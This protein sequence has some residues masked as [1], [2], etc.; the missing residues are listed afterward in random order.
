MK[1]F[2]MM[3]TVCVALL[4]TQVV[5]AERVETVDGWNITIAPADTPDLTKA[6]DA[7]LAYQQIYN[8]IPFNRAEYDANPSYRHDTAVEMMFGQMRSTVVHRYQPEPTVRAPRLRPR[9]IGGYLLW[10]ARGLY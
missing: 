9:S 4:A 1:T 8:S 2:L 3:A 7:G 5:A 6:Q 10:N